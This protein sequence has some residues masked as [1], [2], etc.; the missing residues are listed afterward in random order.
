MSRNSRA[1][2]LEKNKENLLNRAA[3]QQSG[4]PVK[5]S[6]GSGQEHGFRGK[7]LGSSPSSIT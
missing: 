2:D 1:A 3:Q 4:L 6:Q 5:G 7:P